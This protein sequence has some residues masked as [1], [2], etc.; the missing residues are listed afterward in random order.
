MSNRLIGVD[1]DGVVAEIHS[2]IIEWHNKVYGTSH[3]VNDIK[4]YDLTKLWGGTPEEIKEKIREFYKSPEFANAEPVVGAM[5]G[6]RF[7]AS[8]FGRQMAIVTARPHYLEEQ[9]RQWLEE[10]F[11]ERFSGVFFTDS[12]FKMSASKKPAVCK[13]QGIGLMIEDS[14]GEATD[15]ANEGIPALLLTRSWNAGHEFPKGGLVTRVKS[16]VDI[17]SE[18]RRRS[19]T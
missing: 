15:L 16:W 5:A 11:P 19:L 13:A 17:V 9:T 18:V 14:A 1:L 7:I 2:P 8:R 4:G 3:T 6:T 12:I 10:N